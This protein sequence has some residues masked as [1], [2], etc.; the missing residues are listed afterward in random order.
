[1]R[2]R[3]RR[4]GDTLEAILWL[5]AFTAMLMLILVKSSLSQTQE[6]TVNDA[7]VVSRL[8][9]KKATYEEAKAAAAD[10]IEKLNLS[11]SGEKYITAPERGFFCIG[12][13]KY[14]D[15][16]DTGP[17]CTVYVENGYAAAEKIGQQDGSAKPTS[18]DSVAMGGLWQNGNGVRIYLS[19]LTNLSQDNLSVGIDSNGD[20]VSLGTN[21]VESIST[22]AIDI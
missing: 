6:Q 8:A 14:E 5:P 13:V 20:K 17:S 12:I 7:R 4:R 2:R 16:P 1:M 10:Y 11:L 9:G 22:S 15:V 18:T 19:R 21:R 3:N